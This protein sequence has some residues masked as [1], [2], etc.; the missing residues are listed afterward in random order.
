MPGSIGATG[1]V[2]M[3]LLVALAGGAD[4]VDFVSPSVSETETAADQT[5]YTFFTLI[6][7]YDVPKLHNFY[8]YHF[9]NGF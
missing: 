9:F 7:Q 3:L 8:E 4:V 5:L 2:L 6:S 1:K